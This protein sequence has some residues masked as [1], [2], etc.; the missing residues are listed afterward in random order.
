MS[1][2]HLLLVLS[3]AFL[4][5]LWVER[6]SGYGSLVLVGASEYEFLAD[7]F[8]TPGAGGTFPSLCLRNANEVDRHMCMI[9]DSTGVSDGH[10]FFGSPQV[11]FSGDVFLDVGTVSQ[12][13]NLQTASLPPP[14][15]TSTP[16][17]ISG[18]VVNLPLGDS[19]YFLHTTG[20]VPDVYIANA[21]FQVP[22]LTSAAFPFDIIEGG[23]SSLD[24]TQAVQVLQLG[25]I[26]ME[27][28][29]DQYLLGSVLP[30]KY[31]GI[32]SNPANDL[33]LGRMAFLDTATFD[34]GVLPLAKGGTGGEDIEAA[35][36]NLQL[37]SLAVEDVID[38]AMMGTLS[39]SQGGAP[40]PYQDW[41]ALAYLDYISQH[42]IITT[43]SIPYGG[44]SASDIESIDVNFQL[45]SVAFAD[46]LD[47]YLSDTDSTLPISTSGTS[48]PDITQ[49]LPNFQLGSL[50]YEDY[51]S[52]RD[53]T[54]PFLI[55]EGGLSSTNIETA[56]LGTLQLGA[57]AYADYIDL[58]NLD[59]SLDISA[60]G[61]GA[62]IIEVAHANL[63]L[64]SLAVEDSLELSRF[65][66]TPIPVVLGGFPAS[67]ASIQQVALGSLAFE[68]YATDRLLL[69][70]QAISMGGTGASDITQAFHHFQL[71]SLA[72]EDTFS[73]SLLSDTFGI[74]SGALGTTNIEDGRNF[75]QLG[76]LSVEDLDGIA[77]VVPPSK[78]GTGASEI[79]GVAVSFQLGSLALLDSVFDASLD[80]SDLSIRSGAT[81]ASDIE[82]VG[83]NLQLGAL[84]YDDVILNPYYLEGT[85]SVADGGYPSLISSTIQETLGSL[86][87]ED[88][89]QIDHNFYGVAG[90]DKGGT[91]ASDIAAAS[92]NFQLGA[93]AFEEVMALNGYL[94]VDD[95][96]IDHGG[97]SSVDITGVSPSFQLGALA[98]E[99]YVT[100]EHLFLQ[101]PYQVGGTS[102]DDITAIPTTFQLGS[103]APED[104]AT[105]DLIIIDSIRINKGGTSAS[106]IEDAPANLQLGSL[107]FDEAADDYSV[108]FLVGIPEGGLGTSSIGDLT[109]GSVFYLGA[110]AVEDSLFISNWPEAL[111]LPIANGGF[112]DHSH[113]LQLGYMAFE[114]AI[115]NSHDLAID[116]FGIPVGGTGALDITN[117]VPQLQLG[118]LAYQNYQDLAMLPQPLSREQGALVTPSLE[119][120]MESLQLG[121]LA[122]EDFLTSHLFAGTVEIAHGG[123]HQVSRGLELFLDT[124]ALAYE[125]VIGNYDNMF[126][127]DLPVGGLPGQNIEEGLTGLQLGSVSLEDQAFQ[128]ILSDLISISVG[129]TSS[130]DIESA[131][132][133]FQLGSLAYSDGISSVDFGTSEISLQQGGLPGDIEQR[134]QTLQLGSLA[135]EE[136]NLP[137][138]LF[139]T[140]AAVFSI[141]TGG[142]G[143]TA[144]EGIAN[145]QL[146]SLAFL[147][148]YSTFDSGT[149]PAAIPIPSGGT[150]ATD[151]EGL[152]PSFQLG[153]L[154]YEDV[155]ELLDVDTQNSNTI[156]IGLLSN[157]GIDQSNYLMM[158][159]LQLGSVAQL[160]SLTSTD[161][162]GL[163]FEI[164]EGG[165]GQFEIELPFQLGSV[166]YEDYADRYLVSSF[167]LSHGAVSDGTNDAQMT[168]QLGSLS[169]EDYI[170][171][172]LF[173]RDLQFRL[174]DGGTS[175]VSSIEDAR[176]AFMLGSLAV[177]DTVQ[178]STIRDLLVPI[179]NGGTSA[180]EI[181]GALL[182]F[183]L[184]AVSVE[185]FADSHLLS[186]IFGI[187][188]GG[189]GIASDIEGVFHL[190][191]LGSL[192]SE[193]TA[194]IDGF[195]QVLP[196][197]MGGTGSATIDDISWQ[198]G[199]LAYSDYGFGTDFSV[200]GEPP[201]QLI[202]R[203]LLPTDIDSFA[204]SLQL[205]AL[206]SED[207]IRLDDISKT[208]MLSLQMGGLGSDQIEIAALNLQLGSIAM[209]DYATPQLITGLGFEQGMLPSVSSL[210][211]IMGTL[212]L[213]SLAYEDDVTN[214]FD[215]RDL[216]G[217]SQGGTAAADIEGARNN[218][219]LGSIAVADSIQQEISIA[220]TLS[221]GLVPDS[222]IDYLQAGSIAYEDGL[223]DLLFSPI[224]FRHGGTG[225]GHS[226]DFQDDFASTFQLGALAYSDQ[227][228]L[229]YDSRIEP[230]PTDEDGL[231]LSLG[232][233]SVPF[234]DNSTGSSI[235]NGDQAW[236]S[237]AVT[238]EAN[239]IAFALNSAS[240]DPSTTATFVS[241][242]SMNQTMVLR[243]EKT[244]MSTPSAILDLTATYIAS[245]QANWEASEL[246][247]IRF[248][249]NASLVLGAFAPV[250]AG[251][252]DLSIAFNSAAADYAEYLPKADPLEAILP[253]DIIGVFAN[254][255]VSKRFVSSC[256]SGS[257]AES[258]RHYMV[259][260][261]APVV[262]GGFP[263]DDQKARFVLAAMLGK[264]PTRVRGAVRK[265]DLLVPSGF[266]DGTAKGISPSAFGDVDP[267]ALAE[268]IGTAWSE[269]LS[270]E[271]TEEVSRVLTG[272][273]LSTARAYSPHLKRNE[274]KIDALSQT[275]AAQDAKLAS[276]RQRTQ[277]L[278]GALQNG[279]QR[280][281]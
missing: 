230:F 241:P 148:T 35:G 155:V 4:V 231:G 118:A 192:A 119:G 15:V 72:T 261:T 87:W 49:L 26:A 177:E 211:E 92:H 128:Y 256:Q 187:S 158:T 56:A 55:R 182:N 143:A 161:L 94:Y 203:G 257:F 75:L 51:V 275:V 43:L 131:G 281:F 136:S 180:T 154:A 175:S 38:A 99:D 91:W 60:G 260:S 213:G 219:Q 183:Q 195:R 162:A 82:T 221:L 244:D 141:G 167:D 108:R 206:A 194:S 90:I 116:S 252:G 125:D 202:S 117:I 265:G 12:N 223:H 196:I 76:S 126:L 67:A 16:A 1:S 269:S 103:L 150:G 142:T 11:S 216:L 97:T 20:P 24:I 133:M 152:F 267:C 239:G 5:C 89:L 250:A 73:L 173:D 78:G 123:T 193:D 243:H 160:D 68:D 168:L 13:L 233:Y 107:A 122:Y 27:D 88:V 130:N 28:V 210:D 224:S 209:E 19:Y 208:L 85:A 249:A 238:P 104:L 166:A 52:A 278:L 255:T 53:V 3:V 98:S 120:A 171:I 146:G 259:A 185:D 140:P 227:I 191:Q 266:N 93:L 156:P 9:Y 34:T 58:Y 47:N 110:L 197:G 2:R 69:S 235:W 7:D 189:F 62:S 234:F 66:A 225:V 54:G 181:E 268:V 212:L 204:T 42:D 101:V 124:G 245:E 115:I 113:D 153:S 102:A 74:T 8:T 240:I 174:V 84:A 176:N 145:L 138:D 157:T 23:L 164:T 100:R 276:L 71:A 218:L 129:G 48:S 263:G 105:E 217:I 18:N 251:P 63:Q 33:G 201:R 248:T 114:D 254:G 61:T 198:L 262:A 83:S 134:L 246:S 170:D 188:A 17:T 80:F 253:G 237:A 137:F 112:G 40:V 149:I 36:V 242:E 96:R 236:T 279:A 121:A 21:T 45:G 186:G 25:S 273:G 39:I 41:G 151:I 64:G 22:L 147:D 57:L 95:I 247:Y 226:S 14:Y 31:G 232:Y 272:V 184:G 6:S 37:G 178:L 81:A 264:V 271:E 46:Y 50:A 109:A 200:V 169:V 163:S 215:F 207:L 106:N 111:S 258:P 277:A 127:L 159:Q 10:F 190:L 270:A 65:L 280:S 77:D 135:Y 144:I 70:T 274:A 222:Q 179:I 228:D 32:G 59:G 229:R 172:S 79:E 30:V 86:A 220:G 205:G 199:S 29:L 214:L 44:T 139:L 165:T 132:M